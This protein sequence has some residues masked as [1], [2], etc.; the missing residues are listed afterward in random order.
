MRITRISIAGLIAALLSGTNSSGAETRLTNDEAGSYVS[1]YTLATG[2]PYTDAVLNECSTA[3]GRQ[4]EPSVAVTHATLWLSSAAR[5]IIAEFTPDHLPADPSFPRAQSG[6]AITARKTAVGR[7]G[8]RWYRDI[9]VT[10]LR[11]QH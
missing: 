8:V 9:R 11:M 7:F 3:R 10:P 1:T 4:N 6:S 5:T 2:I